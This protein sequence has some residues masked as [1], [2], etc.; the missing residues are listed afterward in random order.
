MYTSESWFVAGAGTCYLPTAHQ[1][2]PPFST[3]LISKSENLRAP[4]I[5]QT[6][7]PIQA[8]PPMP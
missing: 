3:K 7:R 1:R 8:F 4:T 6:T 2:K 5:R